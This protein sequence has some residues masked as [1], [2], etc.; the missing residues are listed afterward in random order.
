MPAYR[1]RIQLVG[2]WGAGGHDTHGW[3]G[4]KGG[5]LGKGWKLTGLES[6]WRTEINQ[7]PIN[8]NIPQYSLSS[9]KQGSPLHQ[10][11]SGFSCSSPAAFLEFLGLLCFTA[12]LLCFTAFL[13]LSLKLVSSGATQSV[14]PPSQ[15]FLLFTGV[16]GLLPHLSVWAQRDLQELSI[17]KPGRIFCKFKHSNQ[18]RLYKWE[19]LTG[20]GFGK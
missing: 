7:D 16:M 11:E 4:A 6:G 9:P 2:I 1:A 13:H 18:R 20:Y 14:F 12:F 17:A 10:G 15:G 3:E 19:L 5:Y 8:S